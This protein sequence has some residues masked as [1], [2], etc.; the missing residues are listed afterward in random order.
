M[1]IHD[2]DNYTDYCKARAAEGLQVIPSTLFRAIREGKPELVARPIQ[3]PAR[4]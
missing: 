2:F 3:N 4:T 1:T